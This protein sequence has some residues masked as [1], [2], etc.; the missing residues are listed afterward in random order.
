MIITSQINSNLVYTD[1]IFRYFNNQKFPIEAVFQFP[2]SSTTAV[3]ALEA[4]ING[5]TI[6]GKVRTRQ[7]AIQEY[8]KAIQENK[9]ASLLAEDE[10]SSD[11]LT[12]SVGNID[13]KM[14]ATV[15]IRLVD[16][17]SYYKTSSKFVFQYRVVADS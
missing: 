17:L 9:M 1:I 13:K 10:N 11:I 5:Q 7:K 15:K 16:D 12:L 4:I 8:E 3:F 6:S 14:P 2:I